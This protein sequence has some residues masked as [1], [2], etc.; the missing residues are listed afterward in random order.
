[1]GEGKILITSLPSKVSEKTGAVSHWVT[2]M[3]G[4]G[5]LLKRR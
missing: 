5:S 3:Q 4:A 2:G 1:M